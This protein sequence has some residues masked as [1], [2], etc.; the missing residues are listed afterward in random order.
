MTGSHELLVAEDDLTGG[1]IFF[2]S[3]DGGLTLP[4]DVEVAVRVE[5]QAPTLASEFREGIGPHHTSHAAW[6]RNRAG[7]SSQERIMI[8]NVSEATRCSWVKVSSTVRNG[9]PH[10]GCH[11]MLE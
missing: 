3:G 4:E 10:I 9:C 8:E 6:L 11:R 2:C 1:E 5:R 7:N